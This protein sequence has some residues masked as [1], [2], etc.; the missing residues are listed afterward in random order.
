M[1]H[2][3]SLHTYIVCYELQH[4]YDRLTLPTRF[5]LKN[6]DSVVLTGCEPKPARTH[7]AISSKPFA[8]F[9]QGLLPASAWNAVY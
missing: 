6:S 8:L 7:L 5:D 3:T 1:L 4:H 9:P 2:R